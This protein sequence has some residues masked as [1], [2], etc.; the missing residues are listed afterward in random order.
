MQMKSEVKSLFVISHTPAIS[1][2]GN[3]GVW[4]TY[5]D[6]TGR[7]FRTWA[8]SQAETDAA[9]VNS[10]LSALVTETKSGNST[11]FDVTPTTKGDALAAF[12]SE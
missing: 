5:A 12:L 11:Y 2:N 9:P 3:T 7:T 10:T 8:N 4:I 6:K 1:Q